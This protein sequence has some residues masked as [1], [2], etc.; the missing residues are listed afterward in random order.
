MKFIL[1]DQFLKILES[2]S[3][4]EETSGEK[5][6]G[7]FLKFAKSNI[8]YFRKKAKYP[9]LKRKESDLTI[10]EEKAKYEVDSKKEEYL[11]NLID[12]INAK[13]EQSIEKINQSDLPAEKKKLER[14][15]I[16]EVRDSALQNAKA[17][18]SE[19]ISSVKKNV[20]NQY[21]TKAKQIQ[22]KIN[23]LEKE[24]PIESKSLDK[25]WEAFKAK[26]D[27]QIELE[28]NDKLLQLGL[29][30]VT[31]VD[32]QKRLKDAAE[33]NERK[34]KV[35][36]EKRI[37]EL[38]AETKKA[39]KELSDKIDNASPDTKESLQKI[40]DFN[41][42]LS[43]FM[44]L[45]SGY[46]EESSED[47]LNSIVDAR[48]ELNDAKAKITPSLLKKAGMANSDNAEDLAASFTK[49]ADD[50]IEE[51]KEVKSLVKS[52]KSDDEPMQEP[53]EP[54]KNEVEDNTGK[55]E[56]IIKDIKKAEDALDVLQA[57]PDVE[58]D[59]VDA[60][61]NLINKKKNELTATSESSIDYDI[62]LSVI[63]N[64]LEKIFDEINLINKPWL[65]RNAFINESVSEK[66]NRLLNKRV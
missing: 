22:T 7:E 44:S 43:R 48:E 41:N 30:N 61:K 45:S 32:S 54:E 53:G 20:S 9:K 35:N 56:E 17:G 15:K 12:K 19:K 10:A 50:A 55:R 24:Y 5:D 59:K 4:N 63:K 46:S 34:I 27:L 40:K 18:A 3:I 14:L 66:F 21:K 47:E 39:E 64:D 13:V 60:V 11:S 23:N 49:D 31:D 8:N 25:K 51:F 29:D 6:Y 58:K 1:F 38:Q 16:R 57:K 65:K 28:Q 42:K 36:G 37:S 62:K 26:I 33:E 52:L 2:S